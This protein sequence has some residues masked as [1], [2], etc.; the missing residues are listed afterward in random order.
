MPIYEYQCQGCD[1][2]FEIKQGFK[3][4]PLSTCQRCGGAVTKLISAPAIMFKGSGWYVTDYSEKLKPPTTGTDQAP[5]DGH[6]K[7]GQPSKEAKP[8]K[9]GDGKPDQAAKQE[10]KKDAPAAA[11]TAPAAS[12][13]TTPTSSTP[14]KSD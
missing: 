4:P 10:T 3:D 9:E 6:P 1:H 11:G 13:S 8:S 2:R 14:A 5:K 7:D 12:G